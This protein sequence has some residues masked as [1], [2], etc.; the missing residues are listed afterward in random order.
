MPDK[1]TLGNVLMLLGV[2]SLIGFAGL[3]TLDRYVDNISVPFWLMWSLG[4]GGALALVA[5]IAVALMGKVHPSLALLFNGAWFS[6]TLVSFVVY[7]FLMRSH[8]EPAVVE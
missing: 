8:R 7:F 6:A 3:Y 5:G 4:I 1:T 2:V